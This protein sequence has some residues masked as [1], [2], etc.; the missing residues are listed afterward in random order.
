MTYGN[1]LTPRWL[2]W[3]S[4][5]RWSQ[6]DLWWFTKGRTCHCLH[7]WSIPVCWSVEFCYASQTIIVSGCHYQPV[8]TLLLGF[9]VIFD[10]LPTVRI[11]CFSRHYQCWWHPV[12]ES[13]LECIRLQRKRD[14]RVNSDFIFQW[15]ASCDWRWVLQA[16]LNKYS[17]LLTRL[18]SVLLVQRLKKI[19][20][21]R[22]D[23]WRWR[24]K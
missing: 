4:D 11:R 21:G 16:L 8:Y 23:E 1:H 19:C 13:K 14:C 5:G 9:H 15:P 12:N 6:Q 22:M 10:T 3:F 24:D 7:R 2:R 20:I 17:Q 18:F